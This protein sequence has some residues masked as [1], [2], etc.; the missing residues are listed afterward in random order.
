VAGPVVTGVVGGRAVGEVGQPELL[1]E[2]LGAQNGLLVVF[3]GASAPPF[4]I[5]PHLVE[6]F[7]RRALALLTKPEYEPAAPR[8]D[9]APASVAVEIENDPIGPM[10]L[11]GLDG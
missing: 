3:P 5:A 7:D 10:P 8:D 9:G 11:W 2:R 1:A 6:P 4:R